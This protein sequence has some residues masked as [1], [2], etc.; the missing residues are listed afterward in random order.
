MLSANTGSYDAVGS[1]R[2][3]ANTGELSKGRTI[4]FT[5][6]LLSH[7]LVAERGYSL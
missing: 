2:L 5:L 1:L 4:Y 7:R 3:L 6:C